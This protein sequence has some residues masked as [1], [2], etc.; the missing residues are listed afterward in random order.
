MHIKN[1]LLLVKK[2][3]NDIFFIL[4]SSSDPINLKSFDQLS[5]V[6]NILKCIAIF[7]NKLFLK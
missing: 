6:K 7:I 1:V 5:S 4:N 2:V 3:Q